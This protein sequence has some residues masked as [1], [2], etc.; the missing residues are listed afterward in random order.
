M[1]GRFSCA[2]GYP[3]NCL[4]QV[5]HCEVLWG[6][7]ERK[8]LTSRHSW[9]KMVENKGGNNQLTKKRWIAKAAWPR[10]CC[11]NRIM[12]WCV[13]EKMTWGDRLEFV[14]RW[15]CR[16][17]LI[18]RLGFWLCDVTQWDVGSHDWVTT[19]ATTRIK[20]LDNMNDRFCSYPD[21]EMR[22]KHLSSS[23]F[24][25]LF[26]YLRVNISRWRDTSVFPALAF[27]PSPAVVECC[28][29]V[30][31]RLLRWSTKQKETPRRRGWK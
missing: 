4:P 27:S 31:V 8:I 22:M 23:F 28:G 2:V 15:C 25:F 18:I 12:S 21:R 14:R 29:A 7:S 11:W 1:R 13:V 19:T 20:Q 6:S 3:V 5:C 9:I 24:L 17:S 30:S 10:S 16:R 26:F